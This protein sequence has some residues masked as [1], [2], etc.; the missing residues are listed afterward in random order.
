V[1]S[2]ENA[3]S[4]VAQL[5]TA[6]PR[7]GPK[8]WPADSLF[9]LNKADA[10]DFA[11]LPGFDQRLGFRAVRFRDALGGFHEPAQLAELYG[12]EDSVFRLVEPLLGLDRTRIV[13]LVLNVAGEEELAGH[14]YVPPWIA[15]RTIAY[16]R[17]H[18]AYLTLSEWLRVQGVTDSLYTRMEPY[19]R[20]D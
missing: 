2:Q 10:E 16:R 15:K 18:G 11:R 7:A 19:L 4:Q 6:K 14:P 13:P 8:P 17:E 1:A 3:Q 9:P 20:L 5:Q 12:L